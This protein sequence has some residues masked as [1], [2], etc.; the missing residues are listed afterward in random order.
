MSGGPRAERQPTQKFIMLCASIGFIALLVVPAFDHRF[1]Q[2][3][4]EARTRNMFCTLLVRPIKTIE[5][6]RLQILFNANSAVRNLEQQRMILL[7]RR[8]TS[9]LLCAE[10]KY[11][12]ALVVHERAERSQLEGSTKAVS[13][14]QNA[15]EWWERYL[16]VSAQ[17][18]SP[19]PAREAH[20]R[21][22]LAR[23]KQHIGK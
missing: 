5:N 18:R 2:T 19:F 10:A 3:Q 4:A 16:D 17:A 8:S 15:G 9:L 22:L 1:H 14:W 13:N 12:T 20:G 21:A 6:A 11:L 7:V 23:C